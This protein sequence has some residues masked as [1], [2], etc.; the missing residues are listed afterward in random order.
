MSFE[1]D[2]AFKQCCRGLVEEEPSCVWLR[3]EP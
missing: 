1:S 2:L 3:A